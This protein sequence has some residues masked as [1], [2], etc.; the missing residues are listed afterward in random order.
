MARVLITGANKGIGLEL[1]RIYAGN[2]DTVI[3]CCRKPSEATALKELAA[4]KDIEIH[5]V[6]IGEDKSVAALATKLAGRPID[7][8]INNAGMQGPAPE[9]Q[10]ALHMDFDGW[11]EVLNIN[12][13]APVRV[14]HALFDHLKLADAPKVVSITSQMGALDLDM[15]FAY[16]YCTSKAALNKF[17]K[18]A[19][20]DLA[21]E[22]IEVCVIHPGWVK[23]DMGGAGADITAVESAEG[24]VNVINGMNAEN[25]G[26]FW[27]W[28]G[29]V[30][31]W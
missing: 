4:D 15:R 8:L 9:K 20:L 1:T 23:T 18:M 5:E 28:N 3:A 7:L 27:K 22:K 17:M 14:M 12:T 30:H 25:S 29:E 16:A 2:G 26:S 6:Q 24:I 31:A 21:K 13:L 10:S 19:A 11:A